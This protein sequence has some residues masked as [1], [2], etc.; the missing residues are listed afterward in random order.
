MTIIVQSE[1]GDGDISKQWDQTVT[2]THREKGSSKMWMNIKDYVFFF[3]LFFKRHK[4]VQ[5][6]NHDT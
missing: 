2:K 4:N 3:L 1:T 6:N 5:R